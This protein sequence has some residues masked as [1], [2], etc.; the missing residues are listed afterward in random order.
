VREILRERSVITQE[1]H[2][3]AQQ[4]EQVD[5]QVAMRDETVRP[6]AAWNP[7]SRPASGKTTHHAQM[8]RKSGKLVE[9]H[10]VTRPFS[11]S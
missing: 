1:N 6:V 4:E 10:G 2:E 11:L 9:P 5:G 8:P 7:S 3:A